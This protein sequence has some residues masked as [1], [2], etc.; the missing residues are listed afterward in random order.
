MHTGSKVTGINHMS[1]YTT[2]NGL[3]MGGW[4]VIPVDLH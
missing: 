2:G 3:E 4:D 1:D